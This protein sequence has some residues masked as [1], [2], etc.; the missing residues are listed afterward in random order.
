MAGACA[1]DRPSYRLYS[2][3]PPIFPF[4]PAAR[5]SRPRPYVV[6]LSSSPSRSAPVSC[7]IGPVVR[8]LCDISACLLYR[9]L[10]PWISYLYL[11]AQRRRT[12]SQRGRLDSSFFMSIS[13]PPCTYIPP[14]S[15]YLYMLTVYSFPRPPPVSSRPLVPFLSHVA[16]DSRVLD[17]ARGQSPLMPRFRRALTGLVE[18]ART[19]LPLTYCA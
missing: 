15:L 2:I 19:S 17:R 1:G 11:H 14:H 16:P 3:K 6:P 7:A 9:S 13:P 5:P 8:A 12:S 4:F 10:P 18:V